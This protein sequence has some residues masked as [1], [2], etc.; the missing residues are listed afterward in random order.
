MNT[1]TLTIERLPRNL[2]R[3]RIARRQDGIKMGNV[4]LI[5]RSVESAKAEC[6]RNG[7]TLA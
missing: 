6:E 4:G 3:V 7:W 5:H 1:H 2:L